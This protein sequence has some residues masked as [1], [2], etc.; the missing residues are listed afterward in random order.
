MKFFEEFKKFAVRGNVIDLAIG[1]MIGTSFNNI[2]SS[3]V[4]DIIMPIISYFIGGMKFNQYKIIFRPAIQNAK[5]KVT[6]EAVSFNYGNFFQFFINF[7]IVAFAMF[8]V[9]KM[10]NK[11]RERM[12]KKEGK[13]DDEA[14]LSEE[15]LLLR[16][17]RDEL[18]KN[19]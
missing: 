6:Q 18:K 11:I 5:G 1:V 2:V 16:E 12:D 8:I 4:N 19:Q 10:I 13:K 17:I 9:V 3:L 14:V 7:L 15:I